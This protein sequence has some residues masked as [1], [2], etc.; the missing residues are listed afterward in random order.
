[1]ASNVE[2]LVSIHKPNHLWLHELFI[3]IRKQTIQ[4][5]RLIVRLDG[6]FSI[7]ETLEGCD[8]TIEVL[9]D[10]VHLG[11]TKSYFCLLAE[12]TADFV[13]LCDQDDIW[14]ENKISN[15][16]KIQAKY[17][18][19]TL[20]FC[21]FEVINEDGVKLNYAACIPKKITKFS[22]LF[23]NG[24]PGNTMM[25]NQPLVNLVKQSNSL[26]EIP[27]WHDW[28]CLSIA[29]EFGRIVG[30]NSEDMKYRIHDNNVVG[31]QVRKLK[32]LFVMLS[33]KQSTQWLTQA[34]MLLSFMRE[35]K[36]INGNVEFLE[37]LILTFSKNRGKRLHFLL[38][39]GLLKSDPVDFLQAIRFYVL[40]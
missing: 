23:S 4:P 1:M 25:L 13:L 40:V 38:Q 8:F 28:W 34:E 11:F 17:S 7:S 6:D 22:F 21:N 29:R 30:S 33:R 18:E 20:A 24:I 14:L 5:T 2:I 15:L 3:S 31:L 12:S 27:A 10:T 37:G 35:V 26:P 16:L 32:K 36:V 39:N 9:E 19:P